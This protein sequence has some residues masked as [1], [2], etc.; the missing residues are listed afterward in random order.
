M[1]QLPAMRADALVEPQAAF[2]FQPML[3]MA[4]VKASVLMLLS[5][6]PATKLTHINAS[7]SRVVLSPPPEQ[8]LRGNNA[9]DC[10]LNI[11]G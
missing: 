6:F 4:S 10:V 8:L 1:A 11:W 9:I 2:S 7:Y 5:V 3:K